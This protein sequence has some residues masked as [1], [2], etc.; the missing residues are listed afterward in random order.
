LHGPPSPHSLGGALFEASRG[1]SQGA[2]LPSARGLDL[3]GAGR[4]SGGVPLVVRLDG[5][6][7]T[8]LLRGEAVEA[9]AENPRVVATAS[10]SA[11]R[12]NSGRRQMTALQMSPGTLLA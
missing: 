12:G 6:A 3:A 7:T 11:A 8:A 9:V 2:P 5:Q 4:A 1:V 10:V